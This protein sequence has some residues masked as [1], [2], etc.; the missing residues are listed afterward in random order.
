MERFQLD[1]LTLPWIACKLQ[2]REKTDVSSVLHLQNLS[3]AAEANLIASLL[4][5]S[6]P[7]V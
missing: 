4:T 5:N 7:Q 3:N 1:P 2:I 6:L